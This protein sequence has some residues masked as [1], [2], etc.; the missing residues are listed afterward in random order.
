MFIN[1]LL[2]SIVQE[3]R[4]LSNFHMDENNLDYLLVVFVP[5]LIIIID[6]KIIFT[7][8]FNLSAKILFFNFY[9]YFVFII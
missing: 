3:S 7:S 2:V 8:I 5:G 6:L 9:L 4:D 1:L